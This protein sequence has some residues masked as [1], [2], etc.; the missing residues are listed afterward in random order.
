MVLFQPS[1]TN[2]GFYCDF[3]ILFLIIIIFPTLLVC[4]FH[5]EPLHLGSK[6]RFPIVNSS[7][8][9]LLDHNQAT[10]LV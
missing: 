7:D 1:E 4:V 5:C 2:Y 8:E 10:N 9:Y 6:C 3:F